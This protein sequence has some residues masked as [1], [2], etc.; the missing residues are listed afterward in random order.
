MFSREKKKRKLFHFAAEQ[1][2]RVLGI[3]S[4]MSQGSLFHFVPMLC[5]FKVQSVSSVQKYKQQ[6]VQC[7]LEQ[8]RTKGEKHLCG[9]VVTFM[10]IK[11][12]KVHALIAIPWSSFC[13]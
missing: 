8:R 11:I 13:S 5:H 6:D 2:C 3:L 9:F 7:S 12:R 10:L 4:V 1:Q